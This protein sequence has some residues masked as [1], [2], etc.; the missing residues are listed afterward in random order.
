M[1]ILLPILFLLALFACKT[2]S[3]IA[4]AKTLPPQPARFLLSQLQSRQLN[5]EWFVAKAKV[6]LESKEQDVSFSVQIKQK[7]DSLSWF[8]FKKVSVE[9]ARA[10]ITPKYVEVLDRQNNEYNKKPFSFLAQ[11]LQIPFIF[12][13]FQQLVVGNSIWL[14]KLNFNS[15]QDTLYYHLAGKNEQLELD[16]YLNADYSLARLNA[17]IGAYTLEANFSNYQPVENQFIAHEVELFLTS[18][19]AGRSRIKIDYSRIELTAPDAV[20]FEIP[21]HYKVISD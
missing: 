11:Q 1:K 8:V 20:N 5:Y 18:P 14:D 19:E 12:T 13:D 10:Q 9:G 2:P 7:R 15:S 16:L 21:D 6:K 4:K 3:K 17:I